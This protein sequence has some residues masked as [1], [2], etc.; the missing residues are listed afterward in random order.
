MDN[1][2][3]TQRVGLKAVLALVLGDYSTQSCPSLKWDLCISNSCR[4]SCIHV[5]P[6]FGLLW[7][8]TP[9]S[10]EVICAGCFALESDF[11]ELVH[12]KMNSSSCLSKPVRLTVLCVTKRDMLMP[13]LVA[14][15]QKKR[16]FKDIKKKTKT[17]EESFT[18]KILF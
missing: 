4:V 12:P 16:F 7:C 8:C 10:C 3:N 13:L 6:L 5:L 2:S 1:I 9:K 18:K 15:V 17:I 11:K 14:V